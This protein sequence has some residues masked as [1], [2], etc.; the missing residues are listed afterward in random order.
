M[1]T[2]PDR[3]LNPDAS[4]FVIGQHAQSDAQF[5]PYLPPHLRAKSNEAATP[6]VALDSNSSSVS[7]MQ[8]E[9]EDEDDKGPF[10]FLTPYLSKIKWI[11]FDDT[12]EKIP[13]YERLT[14]AEIREIFK[15]RSMAA[16]GKSKS[17]A[18]MI[19]RL[20]GRD[21][22]EA[23]ERIVMKKSYSNAK[24]DAS[25]A[26]S[27]SSGLP[28]PGLKKVDPPATSKVQVEEASEDDTSLPSKALF[29]SATDMFPGAE[30]EAAPV[31]QAAAS[32]GGSTP[33]PVTA[34]AKDPSGSGG[35]NRTTATAPPA[36]PEGQPQ[37]SGRAPFSFLG[38]ALKNPPSVFKTPRTK[39]ANPAASASVPS[40]A[41]STISSITQTLSTLSGK[42]LNTRPKRNQHL[43]GV[44]NFVTAVIPPSRD[45]NADPPTVTFQGI[46][47]VFAALKKIDPQAA[48]YPVYSP[49]GSED[50]LHAIKETSDFPKCFEDLQ[51]SY[52]S[53]D[54]HWDLQKVWEG[55]MDKNGEQ[56]KQKKITVQ[57]LVGTNYALPHVL[58]LATT[59]LASSGIFLKKKDVDV[60]RSRTHYGLGGVSA[61][62]DP[63]CVGNRLAHALA[64][65]EEWMQGNVKHGYSAS[66]YAG[67]EFPS[68]VVSLRN[69]RLPEGKDILDE[70]EL[71]AINYTS[72]LRRIHTIEVP[73]HDEVRVVGCLKDFALRGKLNQISSD[74]MLIEL[75]NSNNLGV[76]QRK[77]F[78]KDLRA[79]MNFAYSYS[80]VEYGGVENLENLIYVETD[81]KG[82]KAP[83]KSHLKRELLGITTKSGKKVFSGVMECS[84][85]KSSCISLVYYNDDENCDLVENGI[86]G[87]IAA[88]L[89]QY[90][91][92]VN[93][94]TARCASSI[95][96]GFS[97]AIALTAKDSR[98]DHDLYRVSTLQ[99]L[100]M[101]SSFSKRMEDKGMGELLPEILGMAQVE[102]DRK[103]RNKAKV[104][105]TKQKVADAYRL[106]KKEGFDPDPAD[107]A[108]RLTEASRQTNGQASNR[109]VTTENIQSDMPNL[110]LELSELKSKLE[111]VS[112]TDS[113]LEHP[114]AAD[115]AV[116]NLSAG[117]NFSVTLKA[118]YKDTKDCINKIK[119]R[120]SELSLGCPPPSSG[121]SGPPPSGEGGC[122][123]E[124]GL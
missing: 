41:N 47:R 103:A 56:K 49:E 86:A 26:S 83:K 105:E 115:D 18:Q 66:E 108:S 73:E 30:K 48:L 99:D 23:N 10:D 14:A 20:V 117:S 25:T 6:P 2:S 88:F 35:D 38:A 67:L 122:V 27:V 65:H 43:D 3:G 60:L 77:Q 19:L 15:R 58:Q 42:L 79:V 59:S 76:S 78:Y 123:P 112:P 106:R 95:V 92:H 84:G 94:Y 7:S 93:H 89:Y 62:W 110:R 52:I 64:K 80:T 39:N 113:L 75:V 12:D 13:N 21:R 111:A 100:T 51:V 24:A 1:I 8:T 57:L 54:N 11:Q 46:V 102:Q 121:S 98:W 116:D 81:P 61:D 68:F 5:S 118:F 33:V 87:N 16:P 22:R 96:S 4:P 29:E 71:A 55:Q 124:Q 114:A 9:S 32:Q 101:P 85:S 97:P 70:T 37:G 45:K 34:P 53:V 44:A 72:Y 119:F 31:D 109:S 107:A 63:V 74:C 104:D 120:I 90:L 36:D 91:V 50:A 28:S 69:P 82:L 17:K 40:T